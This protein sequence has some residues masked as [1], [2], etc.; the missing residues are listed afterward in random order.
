MFFLQF[1]GLITYF[2]GSFLPLGC[3]CSIA[4]LL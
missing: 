4:L 3:T 2:N 1:E